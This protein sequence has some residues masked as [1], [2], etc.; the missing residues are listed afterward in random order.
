VSDHPQKYWILASVG[1]LGG[2]ALAGAW[3]E[4]GSQKGV[5]S[6]KCALFSRCAQR[7]AA[8]DCLLG[9]NM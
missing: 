3:K 2:H 1:A 6:I 4:F 9:K 5:R 8:Y 7:V